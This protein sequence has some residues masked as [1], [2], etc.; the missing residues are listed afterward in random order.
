MSPRQPF[1]LPVLEEPVAVPAPEFALIRAGI[2]R[3]WQRIATDPRAGQRPLLLSYD[4]HPTADGPVLIEVNTNAGGLLTAIHAARHGNECCPDWEQGRLEQ[5]LVALFR[6]DLLGATP[7]ATGTLAIVDD[8]L[9]GQPLLPEMHGIAELLRPHAREVLVVDAAGLA[10]ADG[11]LRHGATAIDRIYWRSTDFLL[12]EPRH[13]A[14]RRAVTEGTTVL[15]PSPAAYAAI[16]DKRRFLDWSAEPVLA[17][18]GSG[19]AFRL[20]ETRELRTRPLAEWQAGRA[21]WVFKPPS[22]YASRGVYVGKSISRQKL[23]QLPGDYLAQRYAPHPELHR[24]GADWKYDLRFFADRGEVI[25]A[26]ARVFQGQVVGMKVPGSGF[27]PVRVGDACCLVRALGNQS[28]RSR[29]I[30]SAGT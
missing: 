7:E 14:I 12:D 23:A 16:A 5:R 30:N 6:R 8:A 13:A 1:G 19:H 18:D 22:G 25:G 11:R 4:V 26:V 17:D 21:G 24:A 27:A 28:G 20:A 9:A 3:L 2:A 15:G 29:L 10:Y